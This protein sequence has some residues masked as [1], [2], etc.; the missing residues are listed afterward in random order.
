[1]KRFCVI[2][3][4]FSL[5]LT[6][7]SFAGSSDKQF[8]K[9]V[10]N[11]D[12]PTEAKTTI[13]KEPSL[14]WEALLNNNEQLFK[15]EEDMKKMKGAEKEAYDKLSKLPRFYPQYNSS[16]IEEA[17]GF[18]DT[19]LMDMGLDHVKTPLQ[20]RIYVVYDKEVNAYTAITDN[21]FAICL[22][23]GLL[24]RKG[25]SYDIIMG[26]VA[27]EFTHGIYKHHLQHFYAEAKRRRK[28]ELLGGL[29]MGLE[30]VSAGV[31]AYNR[32]YSGQG[33]DPN[34]T[35]QSI[36]A[37]NKIEQDIVIETALY[38]YAFGREEEYE[39]D[40]V[41]FR[42]LQWIGKGD[43]YIELLKF[44]GSNY[45]YL[46]SETSDHPTISSRIGL[47]EYMKLHP[48]IYN[49]QIEKLRKKKKK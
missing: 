10:E 28:N 16:V 19:L 41:A 34:R 35:Q 33:Y 30:A 13:I 40:I 14:F 48:E 18:C 25:C 20:Y 27:H 38:K 47:I 17:K 23:T 7:A 6:T 15:F 26:V 4:T 24:E 36:D 42:F 46:Y 11:H 12:V 22:T 45:D 21:G 5:S 37:I 29:A 43:V 49:K 1:M 9:I 32:G 31:D 2:I 44:L 3:I 8:K 39:A